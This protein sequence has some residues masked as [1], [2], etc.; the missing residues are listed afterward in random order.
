MRIFEYSNICY[1]P[2]GG[3]LEIIDG[4]HGGHLGLLGAWSRKWGPWTRFGF[5]Y[6]QQHTSK[7]LRLSG[8]FSVQNNKFF[9]ERCVVCGLIA[10]LEC[11]FLTKVVP[12]SKKKIAILPFFSLWNNAVIQ[13]W[14]ILF[15]VSVSDVW[16]IVCFWDV[17]SVGDFFNQIKMKESCSFRLQPFLTTDLFLLPRV[18]S[19]MTVTTHGKKSLIPKKTA[20]FAF[21]TNKQVF[22]CDS[23][24]KCLK[25]I[26]APS[27]Q[28]FLLNFEDFK[29]KLCGKRTFPP[30]KKNSFCRQKN[31]KKKF[32]STTSAMSNCNQFFEKIRVLEKFL[33]NAVFNQNNTPL[34]PCW[35]PNPR[36]LPHPFSIPWAM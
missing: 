2:W 3:S 17:I 21:Q 19:S 11:L 6:S 18:S 32:C 33:P 34:L 12:W 25:K 36:L 35:T 31:T 14:I 5:M 22:F 27:A 9:Y 29:K 4:R 8:F 28:I 24:E 15:H 23:D 26:Y 7:T 30:P 13:R 16:S 1:Q 20:F 10:I